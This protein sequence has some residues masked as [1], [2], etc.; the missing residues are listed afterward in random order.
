MEVPEREE[1]RGGGKNISRNNGPE[2][3]EFDF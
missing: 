1:R 3:P 2:I